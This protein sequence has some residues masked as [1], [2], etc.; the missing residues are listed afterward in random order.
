MFQSKRNIE[1]SAMSLISFLNITIFE[2]LFESKIDFK[3]KL[4]CCVVY[5]H[6]CVC[7]SG[8]VADMFTSFTFM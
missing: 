6:V 8:K 1:Y 2:K 7:I 5:M 4:N 3:P